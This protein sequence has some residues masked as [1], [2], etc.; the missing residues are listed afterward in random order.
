MSTIQQQ[1]E[2]SDLSYKPRVVTELIRSNR[3][4]YGGV[5][6]STK[7]II[8][9]MTKR[10]TIRGANK[11]LAIQENRG[12]NEFLTMDDIIMDLYIVLDKCINGYDTESNNDFY[13]Y[14]NK[15][16]NNFISRKSNY[17]RF[18]DPHIHFNQFST[19]NK[20]GDSINTIESINF[21]EM[22]RSEMD[23]A[24]ELF[25]LGNLNSNEKLLIR[26]LMHTDKV[27]DIAKDMGI[28]VTRY[29]ELL[30]GIRSKISLS[31][32]IENIKA[33]KN[34]K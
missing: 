8:F 17:R 3:A 15:A 21:T 29:N 10:A 26:N 24:H 19:T 2:E 16:I 1:L 31:Q 27:L 23:F 33:G 9:F 11:Y 18:K 20:E 13:Y 22:E 7:R 6:K 5:K 28:T 32:V 4:L 12:N 25:K 30:Q 14:Y 34:D